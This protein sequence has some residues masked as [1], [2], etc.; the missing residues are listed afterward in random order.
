VP[1]S[2]PI[3]SFF[4][5]LRPVR[6]TDR[7]APDRYELLRRGARHMDIS[8]ALAAGSLVVLA[9]ARDNALPFPMRV[10]GSLVSGQ[11]TVFYQFVLPLDESQLSPLPDELQ[12]KPPP[13]ISAPATTQNAR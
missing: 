9:E 3:L 1:R 7:L 12:P 2:V 10:E 8:P 11:G 5:R 13:L 6:K 4:D